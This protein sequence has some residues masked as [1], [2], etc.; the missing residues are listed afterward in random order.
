MLYNVYYRIE[1]WKTELHETIKF[2]TLQF[3]IPSSPPYQLYALP[4]VLMA[5]VNDTANIQV[6]AFVL[7]FPVLWLL[8][9]S[10]LAFDHL[11]MEYSTIACLKMNLWWISLFGKGCNLAFLDLEWGVLVFGSLH[12]VI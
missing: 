9:P 1:Y 3:L 2:K 5:S 6:N 4:L 7:T 12:Y 10:E 8:F 11:L